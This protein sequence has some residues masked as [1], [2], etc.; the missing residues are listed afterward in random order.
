MHTRGKGKAGEELAIGY[1][2]EQGYT[3]VNQN[4][5][6]RH[7]EIDCIARDPDGTLVFL[8]VKV[9][10]GT[11]YGNPLYRV[12]PAK[13]RRITTMARLYCARNRI[14]GPMRLDVIAIHDGHIE[15]LKN[16]F[17]AA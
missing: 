2:K 14:E 11:R 6:T 15:H 5:Q 1:L 12:T 17:F 3:I 4:F 13:Q 7:G 16:A 8:E 10:F 9:S